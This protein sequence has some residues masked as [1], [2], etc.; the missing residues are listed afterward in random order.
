MPRDKEKKN[1]NIKFE[2]EFYEKILQDRPDFV[3]AL[4]ALAELYTKSGMHKKGLRLDKRLSELLP[5]E[6][7]VF[8][9]LAC[10]YSLTG[11]IENSLGALKKA[12][13]LGY[14]DFNFMYNDPDLE[15]LKKDRRAEQIF[16][17]NIID[18]K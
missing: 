7:I 10:S 16:S 18:K 15:N 5:Y 11:D 2:I 17:K 14:N 3:E 6:S 1:I 13:D 9:N 4:K 12:I 8:Y